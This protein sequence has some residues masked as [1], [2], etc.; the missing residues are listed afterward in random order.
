MTDEP[1]YIDNSTLRALAGC[2]LEAIL[3]YG[4]D[5]TT[6]EEHAAL[7][8]G[9]AGHEALATYFREEGREAALA[10]YRDL[11][12]TWADEN[13]PPDDRL[14]YANSAQV[15][16]A[17]LEQ[18][19]LDALPFYFPSPDFVEIGFAFPLTASGDIVYCGRMDGLPTDRTSGLAALLENKFTG[20]ISQ[21]WL[22]QFKIDSQ[23]S[24]YL[25]AAQQHLGDASVLGSYLNAIEVKT[26]PSSSTKC[27]EHGVAYAE[28]GLLHLKS[29]L[30]FITRTPEEIAH[31]RMTAIDLA[32]RFRELL[33]RHPTPDY[34]P[35]VRAQGKFHG[36]CRFCGFYDFCAN[37]RRA[38]EMDIL[39][40]QHP[41]RPYEHAKMARTGTGVKP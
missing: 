7:L 5:Y 11:Y 29:V 25:W 17:W 4:W 39:F 30:T 15:V 19:P 27:K 26:V 22:K 36:R 24:G 28:C 3:R 20:H 12:E 2:D 6:R 35:A 21:D 40:T 23:N 16:A 33:R 8:Q 18:H 9:N 13:L 32:R 37:G 38:V 10:R 34:L 14:T 1:L 41:W 31:W